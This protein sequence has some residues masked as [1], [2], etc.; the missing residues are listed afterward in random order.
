MCAPRF[1]TATCGGTAPQGRVVYSTVQML[2][3]GSGP[4]LSATLRGT[5]RLFGSVRMSK[6][7]RRIG[8]RLRDFRLVGGTVAGTHRSATA[9]RGVLFTMFQ[10]ACFT[11]ISGLVQRKRGS[12]YTPDGL[13][14]VTKPQPTERNAR[15][16]GGLRPPY[17]QTAR[18]VA[19]H[20]RPESF[21]CD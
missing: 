10:R 12:G 4:P 11:G 14:P 1:P 6:W 13:Q 7:H 19:R 2:E 16:D 17:E 21:A 9:G 20:R 5:Q 18:P 8:I 3:G 15:W